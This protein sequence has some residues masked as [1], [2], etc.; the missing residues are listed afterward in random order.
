MTFFCCVY[1]IT[2]DSSE[3]DQGNLQ[4][5][6][7][8]GMEAEHISTRAATNALQHGTNT[9]LV[10]WECCA[11]TLLNDAASTTCAVC[12]NQRERT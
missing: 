9:R 8:T 7:G 4:G 10:P 3:D 12:D 5:G 11:C 2:S 1:T 6:G